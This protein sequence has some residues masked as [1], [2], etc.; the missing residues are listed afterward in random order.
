MY[1]WARTSADTGLVADLN[2]F[3]DTKVKIRRDETQRAVKKVLEVVDSILT[4]VNLRDKR[5]SHQPR[6]AGSY[7]SGLKVSK[8]DEFDYMVQ[9]EGLPRF[10]WKSVSPPRHYNINETG[11]IVR[12]SEVQLPIQV[13]DFG[14]RPPKGYHLLWFTDNSHGDC[15]RAIRYSGDMTEDDD[16]VP[17]KVR[18]IFKGLVQEAIRE[19]DLKEK[20]RLC[21][22]THGPAITLKLLIG[23]DGGISVDLVPFVPN[24][25]IG[26]PPSV[27]E[28]WPRMWR[29]W[30]PADKVEEVKRVGIVSVAKDNLYWQTSYQLCEMA[31]LEGIDRDGGCRKQC[32][33]ILKKLREDDWCRST[34]PVV[35]SYHLKTLL[36]WECERYPNSTD[37]SREKL[38]ER[39]LGLVRE[40]KKWVN[41]R[42]CPHYF[43]P[44]I[45]LFKDKHGNLKDPEN[46]RGFDHVDKKLSEFL[47]EPRR[48]LRD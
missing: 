32:L 38:G 10:E 19:C 27:L 25:G 33:R 48:L 16:L 28:T 29:R 23:S 18:S 24:N 40:L 31:L 22:R 45:N 5:F 15:P 26:L 6:S 4:Y 11:Q 47:N 20:V 21:N 14:T 17:L 12:T 34:K 7:A 36:L 43:V 2:Y 41:D 9:L 39:V 30:P 13:A 3:T 44:E 46:G 35:S 37:W 42:V 8:P 1:E